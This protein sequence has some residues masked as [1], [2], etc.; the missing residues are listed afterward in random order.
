[1]ETISVLLV[2]NFFFFNS[3]LITPVHYFLVRK[4]CEKHCFRVFVYPQCDP[5]SAL[6]KRQV[7]AAYGASEGDKVVVMKTFDE[8]KAVMDAT[9]S[10]TSVRPSPRPYPTPLKYSTYRLGL[11]TWHPFAG[12]CGEIHR[13]ELDFVG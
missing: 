8:K 10:T 4:V 12:F 7:L 6:L 13:E 1:M 9:S 5:L 11:V 2:Y 3:P